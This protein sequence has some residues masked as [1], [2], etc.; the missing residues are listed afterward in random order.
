M[1][2]IFRKLLEKNPKS[3]DTEETTIEYAV[4]DSLILI[5]LNHFCEME[6]M[7]E[8]SAVLCNEVGAWIQIFINKEKPVRYLISVINHYAK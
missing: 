2:E 1:P 6:S 7:P 3:S 8:I 4:I 5:N